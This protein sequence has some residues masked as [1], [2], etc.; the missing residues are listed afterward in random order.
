[1]FFS[2]FKRGM[3]GIYQHC[4]EEHLHHYLAEFDFRYNH[5]IA[6]GYSDYDR[7][8]R[9][10]KAWQASAS[11]ISGLTAPNDTYRDERTAL[12]A[13]RRRKLKC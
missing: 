6:I 3:K 2:I 13:K 1:M 9:S 8:C 10:L 11:H 4:G 12:K 5:R 7:S